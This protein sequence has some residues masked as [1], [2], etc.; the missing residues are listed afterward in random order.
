MG[1]FLVLALQL[2][3]VNIFN[4]FA[5]KVF[6]DINAGTG[7]NLI[8]IQESYVMGVSDF[9]G[10]CFGIVNIAMFKRKTV[11]VGGH[12]IMGICLLMTWFF[13]VWKLPSLSLV[14]V[15]LF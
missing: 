6:G 4:I 13:K 7:T 3:G 10:A 14:A 5:A 11:L 15:V 2:T 9:V 1:V 8:P 12:A